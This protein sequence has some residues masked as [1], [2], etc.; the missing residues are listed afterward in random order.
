MPHLLLALALTF[1]AAPIGPLASLC[2]DIGVEARRP[3]HS[4]VSQADLLTAVLAS[5]NAQ[6]PELKALIAEVLPDDLPPPQRREAFERG[7]SLR[8]GVRWECAEFSGLWAA[9]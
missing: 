8:I 9:E 6:T 5:L 1:P 4:H 3:E 2:E 7:A